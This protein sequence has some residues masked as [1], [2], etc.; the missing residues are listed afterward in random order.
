MRFDQNGKYVKGKTHRHYVSGEADVVDLQSRHQGISDS[1]LSIAMDSIHPNR[2]EEFHRILDQ[3][4]TS[5][6]SSA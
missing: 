3:L 1:N 5:L 6:D 4:K 2:H